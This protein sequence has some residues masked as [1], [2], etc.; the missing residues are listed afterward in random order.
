M[1][2]DELLA[3]DATFKL[4]VWGAVALGVGVYALTRKSEP[5]PLPPPPPPAPLPALPP[6]VVQQPL[7]VLDA[8]LSVDERRAVQNAITHENIIAN[9]TGFA[10]TFEPM[11]PIAASVL[12][13]KAAN[14]ST[15]QPTTGYEASGPPCCDECAEHPEKP[16]CTP[17]ISGAPIFMGLPRSLVRT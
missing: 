3:A 12:R 13:A 11:F 16:P 4:V 1:N 6:P 17:K 8:G 10:S 14:L 15:G 7:P 2:R 9:L 5:E